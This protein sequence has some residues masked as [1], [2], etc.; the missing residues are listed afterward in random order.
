MLG[1]LRPKES[2]VVNWKV[3]LNHPFFLK[4]LEDGSALTGGKLGFPETSGLNYCCSS[5]MGWLDGTSY[6]EM[7]A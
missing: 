3:T 5:S 7:V 2:F 4:N 1:Y 6:L